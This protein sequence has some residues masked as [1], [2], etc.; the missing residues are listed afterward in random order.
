[1]KYPRF[2]TTLAG[3]LGLAMPVA[4][5]VT[6]AVA[7]GVDCNL[8][9]YV[10][11][12]ACIMHMREG[13]PAINYNGPLVCM[14]IRVNGKRKVTF[15]VEDAL[16]NPNPENLNNELHTSYKVEGDEMCVGRGFWEWA[17]NTGGTAAF[18]IDVER[19]PQTGEVLYASKYVYTFSNEQV[20]ERL[21]YGKHAPPELFAAGLRVREPR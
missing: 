11:T 5:S 7:Q 17:L 14:P 8:Q 20:A 13:R 15:V 4:L 18:C 3:L 16:G 21:R 2:L 12:A 6:P 1:M 9:V 19:D 10:N